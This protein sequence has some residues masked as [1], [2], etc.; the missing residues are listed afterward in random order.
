L[1][2]A[3]TTRFILLYFFVVGG[4][5]AL[6]AVLFNR[7]TLGIVDTAFFRTIIRPLAGCASS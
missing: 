3:I 6:L 7:E 1:V 4:L 2:E 5:F